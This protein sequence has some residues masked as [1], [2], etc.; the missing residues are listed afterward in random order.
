MAAAKP[1]ARGQMH[2]FAETKYP[3]CAVPYMRPIE[4][5]PPATACPFASTAGSQR[6]G[7]T[8]SPRKAAKIASHEL[9]LIEVEAIHRI[10]FASTLELAWHFGPR[11]GG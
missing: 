5:L 9:R 1:L 7:V 4:T 2:S 6:S 8:I 10:R 3:V 11:H